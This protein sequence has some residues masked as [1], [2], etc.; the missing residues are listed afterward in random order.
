MITYIY[1]WVLQQQKLKLDALIAQMKDLDLNDNERDDIIR[2]YN[3]FLDR[4]KRLIPS[5]PSPQA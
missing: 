1:R 2:D 3:D 5:I 4:Y